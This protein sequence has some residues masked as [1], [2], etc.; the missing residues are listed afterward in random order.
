[1]G[2]PAKTSEQS[3]SSGQRLAL[4]A[5]SAHLKK[6]EKAEY[7]IEATV[8]TSFLIIFIWPI[9]QIS[10]F[11]DW[12][13]SL[14]IGV[15]GGILLF[16]SAA[17]LTGLL[18][19][20]LSRKN[21]DPVGWVI[22]ASLASWYW[23]GLFEGH[24]W[25][26]LVLSAAALPMFLLFFLRGRRQSASV[27]TLRE[28]PQEFVAALADT[29]SFSSELKS[30]LNQALGSYSDIYDTLHKDLQGDPVVR[31]EALL[32]DTVATL[33]EMHKRAGVLTRM[34]RLLDERTSP[35]LRQAFEKSHAQLKDLESCLRD[36][37]EAVLI[38]AVSGQ[39]ELATRLEE[40]A[41]RL[42]LTAQG[43]QELDAELEQTS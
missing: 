38:Y 42:R 40:Q 26:A 3:G 24:A 29:G 31:S 7:G 17:I 35:E 6:A 34:T 4:S 20:A 28:L 1:M 27:Q 12:L 23:W 19:A 14:A 9:V 36:A 32:A 37:R 30:I 39:K 25:A 33:R 21:L 22:A 43:M 10:V 8:G 18:E 2:S 5:V 11:G 16:F 13:A 15:G 41:E